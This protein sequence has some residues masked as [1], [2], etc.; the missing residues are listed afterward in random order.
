[1][2]VK[3]TLLNHCNCM[4]CATLVKKPIPLMAALPGKYKS[5]SYVLMSIVATSFHRYTENMIV[6]FATSAISPQ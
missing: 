2:L 3:I 4:L 1:M 5:I 6:H